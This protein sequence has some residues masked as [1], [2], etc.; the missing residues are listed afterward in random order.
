MD[1]D[2]FENELEAFKIPQAKPS[3][4]QSKLTAIEDPEP[5]ITRQTNP[6]PRP[7]PIPP[8]STV[9]PNQKKQNKELQIVIER[10]RLFREAALKA[11]QDGNTKV[12]LIYL[13]HAK[14]YTFLL[15]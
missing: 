15:N 8:K 13:K 2:S 10:Q 7:A 12:A 5:V 3:N 11:K 6:V 9:S 14:V 1:L 4:R